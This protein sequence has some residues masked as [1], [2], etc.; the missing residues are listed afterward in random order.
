[1]IDAA[2]PLLLLLLLHCCHYCCCCCCCPAGTGGRLLD[3]GNRMLPLNFDPL[4][5]RPRTTSL[6]NL[7]SRV[8][9][10]QLR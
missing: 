5:G 3:D 8:P 9:Y 7:A 10:T 1:V 2:L 4:S 6:K